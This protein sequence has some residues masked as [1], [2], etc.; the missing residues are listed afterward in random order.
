V[1]VAAARA[2]GHRD[3]PVPPTFFFSLTLEGD[4]P[5]GYLGDSVST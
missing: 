2:A 3:L 5:F 4:S 1:D